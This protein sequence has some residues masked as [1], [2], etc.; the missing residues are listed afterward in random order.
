MEKTAPEDGGC[1]YET[2]VKWYNMGKKENTMS[3]LTIVLIAVLAWF[4]VFD[5]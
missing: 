4:F 2:V 3:F 1:V 5:D